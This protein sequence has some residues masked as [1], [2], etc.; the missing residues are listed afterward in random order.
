LIANQRCEYV[1]FAFPQKHSA[2]S[3]DRFLTA[4]E[5]NAADDHSA[6]IHGSEFL[7]KNSREEHPAKRFEISLVWRVLRSRSAAFRSLEH[8]RFWQQGYGAANGV[9]PSRV[10]L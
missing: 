6:A 8:F 2:S 1:A 7:L 9:L 4:A 10:R 5:V 3:A